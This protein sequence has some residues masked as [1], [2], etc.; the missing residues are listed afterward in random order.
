MRYLNIATISLVASQCTL[1]AQTKPNIVIYLGDDHGATDASIYGATDVRTPQLERIAKLGMVFDRAFIASPA[2]GPSRAA[3]LTGKMPARNGAEANHTYPKADIQVLPQLLQQNGYEVA[4]FGKV[5]HDKMNKT[6]NFDSYSEPRVN[7]ANN[8]KVFFEE[9][10]E[11]KPLC[12]LVGDR[13]PHVPWT[14]KLIYKPEEVKLPSYFID[15]KETREHR[16]MYYSDITGLDTEMG[17]V[18][19]M[20]VERFGDNFIFIYTADHGAQWPFGKWNLY[21]AGIRVPLVVVWPNHVKTNIRTNAMVSWIDIFPTLLDITGSKIPDDLDGKSFAKVLKNNKSK[22]RNYIFTTHSG[23]G[24]KNIYPIRSVRSERYK[25]IRNLHPEFYHSNH[26]DI[27]RKQNAGAYWNSWDS[28]AKTDIK[29]REI[30]SRYYQR[31]A[32]EFYDIISDPTEQNNLINKP[33]LAKQIDKMRRMLDKWM[34]EQ[35]DELKIYSSPYYLY[36]DRP[37]SQKK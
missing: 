13:R 6:S 35:G 28:V 32:E 7:L 5:A 23:D 22:F 3:L 12:L 18:Y 26:S 9:R 8:V 16:S 36:E 20:A 27:D 33:E 24:N 31:P 19:D 11:T 21:E 17:K 2:S 1:N 14:N 10:T 37:I 4:A 15:T 34:I 29:A 25:Y 30:I